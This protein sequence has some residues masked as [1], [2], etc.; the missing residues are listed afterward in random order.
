[1]RFWCLVALLAFVPA[2]SAP[3]PR[4]AAEASPEPYVRIRDA[5]T[6]IVELQIAVRKFESGRRKGPVIWLTGV[7]HIGETN[8]FSKLQQ[9]LDAQA[10]VLFEGISDRSANR[11]PRAGAKPPAS[12]GLT[13]PGEP[14][15]G[16]AKMASLQT[17]MA[18]SLGLAFQLQAIDYERA[19]FRNSD[20]SVQELRRLL[21]ER[22]G[23][24]SFE[25]LL[26]MMEGGSFLDALLQMGLRF[27]GA[28]P[29]LQALSKIALMEMIGQIQGDP[30]QV[31]GLPPDL[32]QLLEVLIEKRDEKVLGDL[33]AELSRR[34]PAASISI[35]F[36]TGHMPDFE[37]R[38]RG[39]LHY[40]PVEEHWLTAFSVNLKQAGITRTELET[41]RKFVESSLDQLQKN[42]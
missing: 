38:L 23:G 31:R 5:A 9:H 15:P 16:E 6:N 20:L 35:F 8:Y 7:S 3:R 1:M 12:G 18:S 29:K 26:Q 10:L 42:Q 40:Q 33:K 39:E 30:A 32:K 17:T 36:G 41:I 24:R 27:L 28:T 19:H 4:L 21:A 25:S 22:G 2:C 34:Q 13:E 11:S 37:R 14:G